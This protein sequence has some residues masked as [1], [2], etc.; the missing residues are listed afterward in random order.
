MKKAF[1]TFFLSALSA[2]LLFAGKYDKYYDSLPDLPI[3]LERV[4]EVVIPSKSI[5]LMEYASKAEKTYFKDWDGKEY[6]KIWTKAINSAIEDLNKAGGGQLRIPA[7][8]YLSGPITLLSNVELYLEEGAVLMASPI[9]DLY[10]IKYFIYARDQKN[11]SIDGKGVIDGN[12]RFWWPII[13]ANLKRGL[14]E[15]EANAYWNDCL[16]HGGVVTDDRGGT[17]W[18]FD[19]NW[20]A[21]GANCIEL[22]ADG[23]EL[24][25]MAQEKKRIFLAAFYYCENANISGITIKDSPKFAFYPH[26]CKNLIIDGIITQAPVFSPNTDS[27]DPCNCQR[28]LIVNCSLSCGDDGII[29]KGSTSSFTPLSDILICNNTTLNSHCGFGIGSDN[30]PGS[31]RIVVCNNTFINSTMG[32]ILFKTP[33]GR[34]GFTKDIYIFDNKAVNPKWAI[35]F[36]TAYEDKGIGGSATAGDNKSKNL[37]DLHDIHIWNLDAEAGSL[38]KA[39]IYMYGLSKENPIYDIHIDNCKFDNFNTAIDINKVK[40]IEIKGCT[41]NQGKVAINPVCKNITFE[42]S[43]LDGQAISFQEDLN[44]Y[45]ETIKWDFTSN[46]WK[47]SEKDYTSVTKRK[48][49]ED[50]Q[51]AKLTASGELK[52]NKES[53]NVTRVKNG[54]ESYKNAHTK[55]TLTLKEKASVFVNVKG[56]GSSDTQCR[57]VVLTDSKGKKIF[58]K[59]ENLNLQNEFLSALALEAGKYTLYTS[60]IQLL[61]MEIKICK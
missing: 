57:W 22:G 27:L 3:K 58:A 40:D 9:K 59:A 46:D 11:I 21:I 39:A 18:P 7:G 30:V 32:A 41:F 4:E 25:Y 50:P 23:F 33:A 17:W 61:D 8:T 48:L 43:T 20:T 31:Q 51:Y 16:A 15:E 37:P 60:G 1:I 19:R 56:A 44:S 13:K 6:D 35:G 5:S 14:S 42:G 26:D 55:F 47:L 34:G 36:N 10:K 29:L 12:G 38:S 28:V 52:W 45:K 54:P 49:K 2:T 53:I 24:T